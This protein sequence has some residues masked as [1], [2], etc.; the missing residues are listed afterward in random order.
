MYEVHKQVTQSYERP[1]FLAS[2]K[3]MSSGEIFLVEYTLL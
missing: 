2:T 3:K 1:T